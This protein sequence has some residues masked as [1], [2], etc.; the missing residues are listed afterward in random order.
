MSYSVSARGQSKAAV[1]A[2][3]E[4]QMDAV[5]QAQ[6][7][8]AHDIDDAKAAFGA[9]IDSFPYT[10]GGKDLCAS[11][12]GS[13]GWTGTQP[14]HKITSAGVSVNVYLAYD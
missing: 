12:S 3:I 1:K 2:E 11:G 10:P 9:F 8:H 5:V 4:R 14:E 7:F 6:P 13:V